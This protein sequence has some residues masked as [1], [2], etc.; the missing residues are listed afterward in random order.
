MSTLVFLEHHGGELQKGSLGVLTKAASFGAAD[1]V[2]VGGGVSALAAEAG[3]YGAKTVHLADDAS[4]E[5][6]LPQPRVDVLAKIVR[7]GGYRVISA[8]SFVKRIARLSRSCR[9]VH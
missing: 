5:P 9:R 7:D 2:L 3:T 8:K 1:A 4:L 6:P